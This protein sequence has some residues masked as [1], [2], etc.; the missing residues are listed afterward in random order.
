[1]TYNTLL[2]RSQFASVLWRLGSQ[3]FFRGEAIW[4]RKMSVEAGNRMGGGQE[5]TEEPLNPQQ[6]VLATCA[7]EPT[8]AIDSLP[9]DDT[10]YCGK[11]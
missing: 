11:T 10:R 3:S 2:K 5:A 7:P 9:K 8:S 4:V 1:M 6:H